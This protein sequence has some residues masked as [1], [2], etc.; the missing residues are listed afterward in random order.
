MLVALVYGFIES[1]QLSLQ[2]AGV[3]VS[4]PFLMMLPYLVTII[5]L[6]IK[7]EAMPQALGIPYSKEK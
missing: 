3:K 4:Y 7:R 5:I 2:I 1:L 6:I